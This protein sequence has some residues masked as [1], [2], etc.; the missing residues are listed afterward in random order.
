MKVI[1]ESFRFLFISIVLLTFLGGIAYLTYSTTG[2]NVESYDGILVITACIITLYIFKK[3]GW[4][5][6]Y[7][8]ELLCSLII[9]VILFTILIPEASSSHLHTTKYVYD[10]GF[11]F[12]FSSI[13]V[14]NGSTFLIPNLFSQGFTDWHLSTNFLGNFLIFYFSLR[15]LFKKRNKSMAHLDVESFEQ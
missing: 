7:H 5:R 3:K 6:V 10:Y 15:F 2:F 13:Y 11:P 14:E 1:V 8:K 9:L 4:G 12:K